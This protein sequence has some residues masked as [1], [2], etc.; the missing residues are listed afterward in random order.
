MNNETK[1][2]QLWK[3]DR[4]RDAHEAALSLEHEHL[5]EKHLR[6]TEDNQDG[7]H[8]T[9]SHLQAMVNEDGEHSVSALMAKAMNGSEKVSGRGGMIM[10]MV[11]PPR[12]TR[13]VK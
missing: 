1:R 7:S 13:E 11:L 10:I 9:M 5:L 6:L 8:A 4:T 2:F 3:Y 12:C